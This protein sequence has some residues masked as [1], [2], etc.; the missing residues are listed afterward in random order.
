MFVPSLVCPA[1]EAP[2]PWTALHGGYLAC[3][4]CDCRF[5]I[6]RT[7]FGT[8]GW[9]AVAITAILVWIVRPVFDIA[10]FFAVAVA[11]VPIAAVLSTVIRRLFPPTL[12]MVQGGLA[13]YLH[14]E[15]PPD[16]RA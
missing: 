1:C 16:D 13:D 12:E 11:F 7:Y 6:S 8:I 4:S 5:K 9:I 10:W 3:P 14:G 15:P 2:I